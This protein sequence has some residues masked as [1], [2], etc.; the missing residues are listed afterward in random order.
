MRSQRKPRPYEYLT[1]KLTPP[2]RVALDALMRGGTAPVRMVRRARILQLL[3]QGW[4]TRETQDAVG[5]AHSTVRR[6][7][8]H[9]AAGGLD[10]ALYDAPRPG[11]PRALDEKAAARVVAVACTPPPE[12]Y[13]RWTVRLLTEE[14]PRRANVPPVGHETIRQVLKAHDLKPWREKNVVRAS[15]DGGVR[16]VYGRRPCDV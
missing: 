6:V 5:V 7:V 15:A 11:G 1:V 16:R 12:G 9:Y 8:R 2:D 3:D 10:R 13:A 4:S 14:A